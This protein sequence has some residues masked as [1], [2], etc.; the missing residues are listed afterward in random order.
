[1]PPESEWQMLKSL[2]DTH[3]A[4]WIIWE[5]EPSADAVN[6]LR[7]LGIQ[8]TVFDPCGNRPETGDFL[9]VME[10]NDNNIKPLLR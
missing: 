5:G 10:N 3:P 7:Q 1:M 6:R 4:K 9:S 8:S 2:L